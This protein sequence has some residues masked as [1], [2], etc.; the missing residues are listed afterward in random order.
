MA[1]KFQPGDA[2]ERVTSATL[3]AGTVEAGDVG[4]VCRQVSSTAYAVFYKGM[5][6]CVLQFEHMLQRSTQRP[7]ACPPGTPGC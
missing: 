7:P 3:V 1:N 6:K 4:R 5:P 2:V